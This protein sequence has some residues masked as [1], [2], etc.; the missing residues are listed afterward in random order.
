MA[1]ALVFTQPL[2][3]CGPQGGKNKLKILYVGGSADHDTFGR[4]TT[5]MAADVAVRMTA[6]ERMLDEYFDDVTAIYADDYTPAMS[7]G[8]DVTV[9][10]G[11]PRQI[12]PVVMGTAANGKKVQVS[13]ASYLPL[14][15]DRPMLLIGELGEP[16][17]RSLGLKIDWYCLCLDADALEVRTGHPIFKGPFPLTMTFADKPTP[18]HAFSYP[19]YS[20]GPIPDSLPMW[21]V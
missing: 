1:A 8:Y 6:F 11:M 2:A 12:A 16:L 3:A 14:D 15:F 4:D 21:R 5:G 9:M 18:E 17:G 19:Y 7:D 10:D 20:D 13:P